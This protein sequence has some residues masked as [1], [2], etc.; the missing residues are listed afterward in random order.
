MYVGGIYA[1]MGGRYV[2]DGLVPWS[3]NTE[4]LPSVTQNTVNPLLPCQATAPIRVPSMIPDSS[5]ESAPQSGTYHAFWLH[6]LCQF[7]YTIKYGSPNDGARRALLVPLGHSFPYLPK[8]A[9][10]SLGLVWDCC[11]VFQDQSL[12]LMNLS[13][14]MTTL[15]T[16]SNQISLTAIS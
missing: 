7:C 4:G 3:V 9:F 10:H 15:K 5:P 16:V 14:Q 12:P 8:S 6:R 11:V 2:C 13:F 1:L